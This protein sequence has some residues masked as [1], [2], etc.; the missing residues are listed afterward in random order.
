MDHSRCAHD[1]V[2]VM[3]RSI[4]FLAL[5]LLVGSTGCGLLMKAVKGEVTPI[6]ATQVSRSDIGSR[7]GN[8]RSAASTD[9]LVAGVRSLAGIYMYRCA[10]NP[11]EAPQKNDEETRLV[12]ADVLHEA[13]VARIVAAPGG[14]DAAIDEAGGAVAAI[15]A[16]WKEKC[17]AAKIAELDR[18]GKLKAALALLGRE[19][20]EGYLVRTQ[21]EMTAALGTAIAD[22]SSGFYNWSRDCAAVLPEASH[23]RALAA[24]ELHRRGAW[25]ELD[26]FMLASAGDASK[27]L[28]ATL[29]QRVGREAL[30]ADVGKHIVDGAAAF[31]ADSSV[32]AAWPRLVEYLAERGAWDTCTNKAAVQPMLMG[33]GPAHDEAVELVARDKC[34]S[35]DD[36]IVKMT[37][38]DSP[39]VRE[40]GVFLIG[41][42]GIKKG[43]KTVERLRWS[44][45]FI[46]WNCGCHPVRDAAQSA[47]NKLELLA[48]N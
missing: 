13:L 20:R 40:H 9:E 39:T 45:T 23:C 15:E 26:S 4:P 5:S 33:R 46:D 29:E 3:K 35:Y 14:V 43:R 31:D 7:G 30:V 41:E 19:G 44:D 12:A 34:R 36:A 37:A 47:I 18:S 8:V 2:Q 1:R 16:G 6:G 11:P 10:K 42:L 27:T 24:F 32:G 48:S 25:K 21:T 22:G 38:S 17:D 28:L